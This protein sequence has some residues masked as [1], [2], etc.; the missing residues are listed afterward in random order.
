MQV[1][2][3]D[4]VNRRVTSLAMPLKLAEKPKVRRQGAIHFPI[5]N[6]DRI[7]INDMA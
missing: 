6:L 1:N 2:A 3:K 4:G 7:T 5:K